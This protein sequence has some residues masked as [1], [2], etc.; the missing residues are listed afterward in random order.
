M[1]SNASRYCL[2]R[3]V[4]SNDV[5]CHPLAR[6]L[7]HCALRGQYNQTRN[8]R[9]LQQTLR[10]PNPTADHPRDPADQSMEPQFV[11]KACSTKPTDLRP[12]FHAKEAEAQKMRSFYAVCSFS[13]RTTCASQG[14]SA[15]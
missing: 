13:A 15:F 3:A 7:R 10:G 1:N 11:C 12:N 2:F 8:Q 9:H 6:P 5:W 4:E 14:F